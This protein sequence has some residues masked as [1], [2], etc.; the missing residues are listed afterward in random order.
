M[1]ACPE[2]AGPQASSGNGPTLPT[3]RPR[4]VG[5]T[6]KT[7][8]GPARK[9]GQ[10]PRVPVPLF[11]LFAGLGSD[12]SLPSLPGLGAVFDA[13]T[14]GG[15]HAPIPSDHLGFLASSEYRLQTRPTSRDSQQTTER[16]T[17]RAKQAG[18]NEQR[19]DRQVPRRRRGRDAGS[20][21]PLAEEPHGLAGKGM[22]PGAG[23][24]ASPCGVGPSKGREGDDASAAKGPTLPAQ[25]PESPDE[26]TTTT[27]VRAK[28]AP[29]EQEAY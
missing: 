3:Y 21:G 17:R 29:P 20:V 14:T 28:R 16:D 19:F 7:L 1:A 24:A 10:A 9:G 15:P 25:P 8:L 4:Q 12:S 2:D 18:P 13:Q 22:E 26:R 6:S 5:G 23:A 27:P 11:F